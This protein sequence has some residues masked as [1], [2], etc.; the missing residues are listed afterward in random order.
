MQLQTYRDK[1][2]NTAKW[3]VLSA[4]GH[5]PRSA[6]SSDNLP[7]FTINISGEAVNPD[8]FFSDLAEKVDAWVER[9]ANEMAAQ[10]LDEHLANIEDDVY[11][12]RMEFRRRLVEI[13]G[14]KYG[15]AFD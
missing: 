14:I 11:S 5:V 3:L 15:D 1:M 2:S 9:H 4:L 8:E 6:W 12:A 13:L 10:K 7:D